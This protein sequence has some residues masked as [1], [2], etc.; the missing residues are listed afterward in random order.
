VAYITNAFQ[1]RS[2]FVAGLN[3]RWKEI[4]TAKSELLKFTQ[5]Q[6]PDHEAYLH[7]YTSLS[8]VIDN[9][10]LAFRNVGE[11]GALIGLYP[12]APLHDMRRALQTLDPLTNPSPSQ[13]Q[14]K[15]VRNAILQSFYALR[16]TFLEELDLEEPANPMLIHGARRTKKPGSSRRAR[17]A[18]SLQHAYQEKFAPGD[19]SIN[20]MLKRLHDEELNT[21]TRWREAT[22]RPATGKVEPQPSAAEQENKP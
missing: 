6:K 10:R 12:F 16:E 14:R 7:A 1:G 18:Q 8:E 3:D 17:R 9:M 2:G 13:D 22:A 19:A 20:E 5:M 11:T 21:A 4:T 15:L